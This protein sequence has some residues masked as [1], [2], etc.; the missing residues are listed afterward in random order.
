MASENVDKMLKALQDDG[1]LTAEV[2]L[3]FAKVE[4]AAGVDLTKDEKKEFLKELADMSS[5]EVLIIWF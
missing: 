3:A 1:V 4:A 5:R 2:Q